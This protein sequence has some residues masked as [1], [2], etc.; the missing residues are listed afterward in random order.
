M[1]VAA[2][3]VL[4]AL[5][6]KL[7]ADRAGLQ[8]SFNDNLYIGRDMDLY[9]RQ[10]D[11]I[12]IGKVQNVGAMY[13]QNN[14]SLNSRRD[15]AI[16]VQEVL[17]GDL[18]IGVQNVLLENEQIGGQTVENTANF[19]NDEKVLLF[20]GKINT[21]EYVPFAGPFGKYIINSNND[22]LGVGDFKMSLEDLKL[23]ILSALKTDNGPGSSRN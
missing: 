17:K 7:T 3:F 6:F 12:V 14:Q 22:V 13:F 21:G 23:K 9:A 11:A 19:Q 10:V 20:L 4:G 2:F 5:S 15:I 8:K 16:E 1:G 18:K